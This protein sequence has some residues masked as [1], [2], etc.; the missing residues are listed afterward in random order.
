MRV[1]WGKQTI[2]LTLAPTTR[3]CDRCGADREFVTALEYVRDWIFDEALCQV[4][5]R[6]YAAACTA[7]GSSVDLD[8][9]Q[10]E[11]ELGRDPVPWQHRYGFVIGGAGIAI[12]VGLVLA[13]ARFQ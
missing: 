2:R 4:S 8:R 3:R 11:R 6:R 13:I 10:I 1:S 7:C 9:A 5:A 12:V